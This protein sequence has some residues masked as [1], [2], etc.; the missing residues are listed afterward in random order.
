MPAHYEWADNASQ[1][2]VLDA[3]QKGFHW[4]RYVVKPEF[5]IRNIYPEI[6]VVKLSLYLSASLYSCEDRIHSQL[7]LDKR[8]DHTQGF[9]GKYQLDFTRKG[10]HD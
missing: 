3:T 5:A 2:K 8:I 10:I 4:F 1:A 7:A 6:T 9:E